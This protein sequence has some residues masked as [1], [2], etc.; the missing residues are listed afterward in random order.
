MERES[1]RDAG[2]AWAFD[3]ISPD[4][5]RRHDALARHRL[6]EADWLRAQQRV[7]SL[8]AD[9]G[10]LSPADPGRART[11]KRALA[12]LGE[13]ED[14]RLI[15]AV[16]RWRP[17][18]SSHLLPIAVLYLQWEASY[19]DEW[20]KHWLTKKWLLRELSR[21]E[22]YDAELRQRLGALVLAAVNREHRCE[23]AGYARLARA[24]ADDRLIAQLGEAEASGDGRTRLRA[25]FMLFFIA[26]PDAAATPATWRRWLSEADP[27]TV[28]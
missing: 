27:L 20:C 22:S 7:N 9:A 21:L 19:P 13:A 11:M 18:V 2:L 28:R 1:D 24:I 16:W 12:D 4:P 3:L 6:V 10:S 5:V 23:D 25:S 17:G 26:S 14:R 15:R 8:W